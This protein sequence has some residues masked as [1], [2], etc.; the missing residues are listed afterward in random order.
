MTAVILPRGMSMSRPSNIGRPPTAYLKFRISMMGESWFNCAARGSPGA[1]RYLWVLRR[2]LFHRRLVGPAGGEAV[3]LRTHR[4]RLLTGAERGRLPA[5]TAERVLLQGAPIT[6]GQG[7]R[8]R[9]AG[10]HEAQ[11]QG[12]LGGTLPAG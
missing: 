11:M 7:P 1:P 6:E 8:Q 9:T 3:H 2:G 4:Q 12:R 5:P 10:V